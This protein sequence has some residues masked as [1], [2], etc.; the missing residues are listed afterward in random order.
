[1][2][3]I[4]IPFAILF[5]IQTGLAVSTIGIGIT[6]WHQLD[7]SDAK[8][9]NFTGNFPIDDNSVSLGPATL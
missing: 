7:D 2:S 8:I 5:F 4:Q 3:R 6:I 9:N 1:M